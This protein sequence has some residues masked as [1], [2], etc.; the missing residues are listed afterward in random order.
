[1]QIKLS[2]S[3]STQSPP[4]T[5][6]SPFEQG[7]QSGPPQSTSVSPESKFPLPHRTFVGALDGEVD[8]T[9]VGAAETVWDGDWDGLV[10]G[11]SVGDMVGEVDGK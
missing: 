6:L 2:H 7:G 10:V 4:I 5:Q 3:P 11:R 8:G 1:M 9:S